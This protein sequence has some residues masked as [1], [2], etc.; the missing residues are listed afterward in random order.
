MKSS[1]ETCSSLKT[2]SS[3]PVNGIEI[4]AEVVARPVSPCSMGDCCGLCCRFGAIVDDAEQARI[5]QI[6][7][8]LLPRLRPDARQAIRRWGWAFRQEVHERYADPDRRYRATRVAG[9]L[10]VFA[11]DRET[12]G[13]ALHQLALEDGV[14]VQHY[15]PR[16]C[17]LFPLSDVVRG[18]LHLHRWPGYPCTTESRAA[19]P[20]Y[21]TLAYELR[22]VLGDEGYAALEASVEAL[23]QAGVTFE[24]EPYDDPAPVPRGRRPGSACRSGTLAASG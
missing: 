14:P 12:G 3:I 24:L 4:G 19:A 20:A 2:C 5:D 23:S 13:C 1:Q 18:R 15:K 8:R 22:L 21:R 7:P 10:C 6:L 16:E 9:G 11:L 17:V